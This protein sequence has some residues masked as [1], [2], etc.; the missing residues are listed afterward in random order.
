[1]TTPIIELQ[2]PIPDITIEQLSVPL[3]E[4]TSRAGWTSLMP[5][6]ARGIPYLLAG[7]NMMV[8]ARTGSGKTGAFLL[9]L[10]ERLDPSRNTC[11][12][13]ILVPT[14]ELAKQVGEEAETLFRT[15]GLRSATVYG[16]VGYGA[17]A[18]ALT[19]GAQV[20]VG[21]PGRVL[22]H[23]LKRTFSLEHLKILLFDEADR[24]LS[25]GFYPDMRQLRRYLPTN[26]ALHT[27]MFSATFPASVMRAAH[28]FIREPEFINLSS[29]H[30]HVSE[31]EHVYYIVPG[32]D[33][34]RSLVRLIEV[35]N[36]ASAIIFC[37]T[38][39]RV[40]Y[41]AVVLQRFGYDA[42]EIS[43]D[44][45]QSQR[46]RVLERV[47]KGTLRFLVAT[48]VAA[49]GLDV[50]ELTHVIQYE[51]PDEIENY[52]HRA[53][54]TGRAGA[55]GTAISLVNS[56]ERF[57]L[58]KIAKAYEIPMR[59]LPIPSDEDV[60]TVV[61]ERL[62][63]L[64]EARLR[65]RDKLRTER[66]HRFEPLARALAEA[67]SELPLITMLLDDTYQ[68][69]QHA[70]VLQPGEEPPAPIQPRQKPPRPGGGNRN[71]DR[72]GRRR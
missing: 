19:S 41:V 50:P 2:N 13:L 7:R 53:G 36:P 39:M 66:S 20:V 64:L 17:Q 70:P 43:A 32:M 33:K 4:A 46:E 16:G 48:D 40:N 52:I 11:Q 42:D 58:E 72:G 67:E 49:R 24:M 44:L 25:M 59:E 35:E 18:Q 26:R 10:L 5:V 1:L 56:G 15:T 71:R 62:T 60:A 14:R 31:V 55:S 22:D 61:A 38:K 51:P 27:C 8:Q 69:M 65:E 28:E 37:N 3:R 47:R 21:T 29:D 54:R 57:T 12:A 9:P 63:A 23:L 6:Q 30:V 45:S 68:Q 34:D